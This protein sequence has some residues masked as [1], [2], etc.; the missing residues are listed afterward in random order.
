MQTKLAKTPAT[1][2]YTPSADTAECLATLQK[3]YRR[4]KIPLE[5]DQ[6][7]TTTGGSETI[8]FTLT[9]CAGENNE[10]LVVEPFYTNY[11]AFATMAGVRLVP[12]RP[13]RALTAA[14]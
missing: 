6:I 3:Y 4:L 13:R 1:Y 8:L 10:T 5:A 7:V 2:A 9:A 14:Q 11:A 12:S